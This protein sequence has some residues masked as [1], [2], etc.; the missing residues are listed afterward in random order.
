MVSQAMRYSSS[1][2]L[3]DE[4]LRKLAAAACFVEIASNIQKWELKELEAIVRNQLYPYESNYF[5]RM[6]TEGRAPS[7]KTIKEIKKVP[8]LKGKRCCIKMWRDHKFWSLLKEQKPTEIEIDQ[9][10]NAVTGSVKKIIWDKSAKTFGPRLL[11]NRELTDREMKLLA[12]PQNL[13]SLISLTVIAR[14]GY[15]NRPTQDLLYP[16]YLIFN[17]FPEVMMKCPHLYIRWKL[18]IECLKPILI[19]PEDFF[20]EKYYNL[21]QYL[22]ILPLI[23]EKLDAK[24]R[25]SENYT[26][27]PKE[28]I[29]RYNS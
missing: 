27:P 29:E 6:L 17:I 1:S 19:Q 24:Y 3:S 26:L 23:I 10:L 2:H 7:N 28:L 20:I 5:F 22:E 14:E 12:T 9:A 13:S 4:N 25:K 11:R 8:A 15:I 16:A 21:D 18:L